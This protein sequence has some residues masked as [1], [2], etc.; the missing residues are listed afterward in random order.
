MLER[1]LARM[2]NAR[3][4]DAWRVAEQRI[5]SRE[6]FLVGRQTELRRAKTVTRTY[7][8]MY[9]DFQRQGKPRRGS[10]TVRLH[11]T[12]TRGELESVLRSAAEAALQAENAPYPLVEPGGP[13]PAVPPEALACPEGVDLEAGLSELERALRDCAAQDPGA[14]LNSAELFVERV[15]T[16]IANSA[17]L[18]VGWTSFR[19]SGELIVEAEGPGGS[20]ELFRELAFTRPRPEP[21]A[22]EMRRLQALCRD[23][24]AA[25]P[26]HALGSVPLLLTGEA[27]RELGQYF[28]FHSAAESAYRNLARFRPGESVQGEAVRGD[29]LNLSLDPFLPYSPLSSPW[30]EDGWPLEPVRL[31]EDGL[32]ARYWGPVQYCHYLG[33]PPT[34]SVPNLRLRPGGR[35]LEAL[36]DG[37]CLEVAVF[38]DFQCQPL[39]GDFAGELRLAYWHAPDGSRRPVTGGSVSGCLAELAGGLLLSAETQA[40]SGFEGPAGV[41]LPQVS[42]TGA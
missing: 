15:G 1:I 5:E 25:V 41:L 9:R 39:T 22:Q 32:L 17:G 38:S 26:T 24:A 42:V 13:A 29:V 36:R 11:P 16:S 12:H 21:L 14:R 35:P 6:L 2:K 28:L 23:R 27:V 31:I 8:T 19:G 7:L 30:D 4:I 20:V 3:H 34:G 40:L 18:E 10:A 37:G 33:I